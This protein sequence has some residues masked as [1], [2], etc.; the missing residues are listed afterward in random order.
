MVSFFCVSLISGAG[1]ILAIITVSS[2]GKHLLGVLLSLEAMTLSLFVFLLS[3]V[4]GV[5]LECY[6]CLILATF[7]AC[8]ASLGLAVLVSMIRAHGNDYV[9]SFTPHKC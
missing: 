9:S 2:Q 5:N 6:V 7:G 8:E 4:S 1:V 3:F